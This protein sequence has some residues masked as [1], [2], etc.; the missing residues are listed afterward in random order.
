MSLLIPEVGSSF[1][2]L[3]FQDETLQCKLPAY[4]LSILPK[5]II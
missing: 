2:L 3:D 5:V 1:R 4:I